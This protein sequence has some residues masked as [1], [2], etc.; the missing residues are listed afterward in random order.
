MNDFFAH[1]SEDAETVLWKALTRAGK[2]VEAIK[3][4]REL[5]KSPLKDAKDVVLEY[6]RRMSLPE[7]LSVAGVAKWESVEVPHGRLIV[8][9]TP[10]GIEVDR[11]T[12]IRRRLEPSELLQFIADEVAQHAFRGPMA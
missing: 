8:R 6:E 11:V 2:R 10:D 3:A 4:F 5:N 7:T 12:T 9:Y 1:I